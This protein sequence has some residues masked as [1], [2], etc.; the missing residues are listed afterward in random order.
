MTR[1]A[2]AFSS[3]DRCD[4]SIRSIEPLLG[5][6]NVD[7][8]WLDGSITR[9]GQEL[10]AK[11]QMNAGENHR[12]FHHPNVKG[13][14]DAAIVYALT[15]MLSGQDYDYV[16][17]VENDVMLSPGWLDASLDL[18]RRGTEDGLAVGAVSARCYQDRIL[19]QRDGYALMHNLGAGQVIFT[20]QAA[21][22]ILDSFRTTYTTENRKL[23]A[24]LCG[25]DIGAWWAFRASEHWLTADWAFDKVLASH[26]L[27]SLALTPSPCRMLDQDPANVG[28]KIV[29]EPFEL[30]RDD[31]TFKLFAER[32]QA[33]RALEWLPD[34]NPLFQDGTGTSVIFPHQLPSIGG[35]YEGDWRLKWQQGF[36]PFAWRANGTGSLR[37][38]SVAFLDSKITIPVLGGCGILIS[39][40]PDGGKV[41]VIDE[42][43]G[44][45]VAPDLPPE[46]E[47]TTVL[48]IDVPGNCSYRNIKVTALSPGATFYGL[49]VRDPQP[50]LPD[51]KFDHSTLPPV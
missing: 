17:L 49:R 27:A 6:P 35:R 31:T 29:E 41:E 50:W 4:L 7:I 42:G 47:Q 22:L 39:G 9:E 20:R 48:T 23:F 11:V 21:R 16:G 28:L 10:P 32:T 24:Q 26:G 8:F 14:A 30:L 45:Q 44:Y 51:V 33:I 34:G 13:G 43:T 38:G 3:K 2:L 12:I 18:F 5:L 40:G 36:G 37:D 1:I 46:G 15:T 25:K 19:C